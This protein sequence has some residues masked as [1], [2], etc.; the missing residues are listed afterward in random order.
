[1]EIIR[2]FT[3]P[4]NCHF[5]GEEIIEV[6]GRPR[7]NSLVI[8]SLDGNHNNWDFENKVPA[9]NHCHASHHMS[10][11]MIGERNP[12]WKGDKATPDSIMKRKKYRKE[13]G[14]IDDD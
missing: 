11:K 4:L 14:I 7:E 10:K 3:R 1:M 9:H 5:C 2:S 6:G 13:R 12:K 8:H